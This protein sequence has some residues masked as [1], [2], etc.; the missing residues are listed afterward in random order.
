MSIKIMS[1]VWE[2]SPTNSSELLTMLALSDHADDE[3][4]CW[5]SIPL[6][7][8]KNRLSDRQTQRVLT[9]LEKSGHV[10]RHVGGGRR[11]TTIYVVACGMDAEVLSSVLITRL[12]MTPDVAVR[13]A[14]I[15]IEKQKGD[16]LE[17]VTSGGERVTPGDGKGDIPALQE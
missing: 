7:S 2:L 4:V 3:G 6:I 15:I 10:F 13:V 16:I 14:E 8:K 17:T 5:P 11:K 9:S 12:D 1:R